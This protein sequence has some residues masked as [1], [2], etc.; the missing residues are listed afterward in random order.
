MRIILSKDL[1]L[2][3]KMVLK[4]FEYMLDKS[5]Q[6]FVNNKRIREGRLLE[7]S[8]WKLLSLAHF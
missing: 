1:L 3:T 2:K 5:Y 7:I 4:T 8:G 6:I